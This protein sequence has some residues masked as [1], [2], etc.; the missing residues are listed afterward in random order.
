MLPLVLPGVFLPAKMSINTLFPDALTPMTAVIVPGCRNEERLLVC[1]HE[2]L[3]KM[4]ARRSYH[5]VP[6]V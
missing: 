2:Q 6:T 1:S 4:L 5:L 3:S